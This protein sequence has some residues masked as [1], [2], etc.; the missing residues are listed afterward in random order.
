MLEVVFLEGAQ[1]GKIIQLNF[2]KAWFG[3]Q[4]TC[5]FVLQ[6]EGIS[7]VHFSIMQHGDEYVLFDNQSTNGT[8]VN[9]V[10]TTAVTLRAGYRIM[11]G[12]NVMEVREQARASTGFHFIAEWKSGA[13]APQVLDRTT[14]RLGRKDICQVQLNDP[15]VSLIHAELERRPDGVWIT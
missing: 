6:G 13:E 11:A 15:A 9:A 5:D 8:F 14:I 1:R 10:K 3:R 4:P 7:R 12:S 2:Q